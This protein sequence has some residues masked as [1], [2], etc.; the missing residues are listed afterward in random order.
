MARP[1]FAARIEEKFY[2]TL[3]R[4]LRRRGWRE[5]I[6]AYTGYG[7]EGFL[8]VMARLVL[9]PPDAHHGSFTAPLMRRRGWRNFFAVP[10]VYGR[11]SV[12][13]HD[14]TTATVADRNGYVDLRVPAD[15]PPGWHEVT[16]SCR[17]GDYPA[18]IMVVSS[19][20]TFGLISDLDDTVISTM[21]PR[22]WIAAWNTFVLHE[23][24]RQAVPGM[25]QLYR[26]LLAGH[27]T[28]PVFYVST[29]AWNTAGTLARF[30]KHGEFPPG[31]M[32]L[33]DWGPT[34]TGWFRSGQE[35]K[36]TSL[37]QLAIDLPNVRWL[38]VGDDGQHD[39][40]LYGEFAAKFPDRVRAIA[41]RQLSPVE[42]L[43]AHGTTSA[44]TEQEPPHQAVPTV[45]A[46]DGHG[47]LPLLQH[48]LAD[49]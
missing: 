31:P 14:S 22:I 17:S 10:V 30:L 45:A 21:L 43:L 27:P 2:T 38:L 19:E 3:G 23:T 15:L 18:P 24:A 49:D 32:M 9:V 7:G 29:G 4:I 34:N 39:P 42:Q 40:M 44:L 25:S 6:I 36:R 12:T 37:R 16:L 13:V 47:L 8:R 26:E 33:T 28:A 41:L 1:F 20:E 48:V 35:H 11:M 5:S 46:P